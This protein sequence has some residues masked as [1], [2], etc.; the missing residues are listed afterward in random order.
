MTIIPMKVP[1]LGKLTFPWLE[2]TAGK[3]EYVLDP[4]PS[5]PA[6]GGSMNP[7]LYV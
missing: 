2:K 4:H 7:A 5:M 1:W 3:G 6:T